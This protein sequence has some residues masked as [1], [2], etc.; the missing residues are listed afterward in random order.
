M[1]NVIGHV[2]REVSRVFLHYLGHSGSISCE[3][4][5]RRKYGKILEVPCM[6]KFLGSEKMVQKMRSIMLKKSFMNYTKLCKY[7]VLF[8]N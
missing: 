2:P 4:T 1:E 5:G 8:I 6:F 7:E 3:V